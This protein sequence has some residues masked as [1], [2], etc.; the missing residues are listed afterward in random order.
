MQEI[1]CPKCEAIFQVDESSY[2]SIAKQIR[3]KEFE[4]EIEKEILQRQKV[5]EIE[6][7]KEELKNLLKTEKAEKELEIADLKNKIELGKTN[8][9]LAINKAVQEKDKAILELQ[10]KIELKDREWE[11]KEKSICE[12]HAKEI[13]LYE[14]QVAFYKDFKAKQSTKMIGESLE[15][16]CENEFN[17]L[18]ATAF[19]SAFFEK[20]ND[21][22]R[23]SK[24]DFIYRDFSNGTEYISIMFEMKNQMETTEKKHKNEDFFKS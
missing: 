12:E 11:L 22:K 24:G 5:Y 8:E 3:D 14:D 18:R 4:K 21:I 9:E 16:H 19:Q 17:K 13:K 15:R 6:K 1:K 10:N 20:D 7:E 23:G 2:H